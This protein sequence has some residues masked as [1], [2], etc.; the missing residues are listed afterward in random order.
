MINTNATYK[1]YV[2][3][4]DWIVIDSKSFSDR[5][6]KMIEDEERRRKIIEIYHRKE[7]ILKIK[8]GLDRRRNDNI[9]EK[10]I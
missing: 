4:S 10:S 5:L 1:D 2:K 6:N 8:D 9:R 7:K 3:D